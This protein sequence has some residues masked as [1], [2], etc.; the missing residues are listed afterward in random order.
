[1]PSSAC[2]LQYTAFLL[3]SKLKVALVRARVVRATLVAG[4]YH[5]VLGMF[6][7]ICRKLTA[8]GIERRRLRAGSV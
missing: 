4:V 3:L 2:S 5:A 1:M 6:L 7:A 8:L